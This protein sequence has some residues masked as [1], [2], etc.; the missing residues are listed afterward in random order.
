[1]IVVCGGDRASLEEELGFKWPGSPD[2]SSPN[3]LSMMVFAND[4]E[5]VSYFES[6]QDD[7]YVNHWYFTPCSVPADP[8]YDR[9][10]G[11]D[12]AF[13]RDSSKLT[14]TFQPQG[15]D[16]SFWYVRASEL[17]AASD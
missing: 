7:D 16:A 9:V 14:F 13:S 11:M 1:M 12:F 15:D 8:D 2:L 5:V 10:A 4:K 6:G 17:L 3:F